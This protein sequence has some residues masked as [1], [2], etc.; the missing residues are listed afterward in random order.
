LGDSE[1]S[2]AWRGRREDG[3]PAALT[4]VTMAQQQY[5]LQAQP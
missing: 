2:L 3:N 4:F 5:A 1:V